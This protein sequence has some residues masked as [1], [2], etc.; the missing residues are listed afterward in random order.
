MTEIKLR[1]KD[2]YLGWKGATLS[3][4]L[5][6]VLETDTTMHEMSASLRELLR[7][8]YYVMNSQA[9]SLPIGTGQT[10][11][12]EPQSKENYVELIK[13]P[14]CLVTTFGNIQN[15][16]RTVLADVFAEKD[17]K[18]ASST[19]DE[20]LDHLQQYLIEHDESFNVRELYNELTI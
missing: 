14:I 3:D 5:T 10:I 17:K 12:L 8:Y 18:S 16:L 13:P 1:V 15:E 2:V 9:C 4:D 19:K 20:E 11:Q 6:L 7:L